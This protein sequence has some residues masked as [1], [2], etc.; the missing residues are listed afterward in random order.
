M[1]SAHQ[2]LS[3]PA[4]TDANQARKW[5][6]VLVGASISSRLDCCPEEGRGG[7]AEWGIGALGRHTSLL[8]HGRV[9][10][11]PLTF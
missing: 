5:K 4:T 11:G 7:G 6:M 8:S 2:Y 10:L 9:Q 1:Y 3:L